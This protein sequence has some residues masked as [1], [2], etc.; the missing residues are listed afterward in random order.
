MIVLRKV[1]SPG[2]ISY[3]AFTGKSPEKMDLQITIGA[4]SE[5]LLDVGPTSIEEV[6]RIWEQLQKGHIITLRVVDMDREKN[7][8]YVDVS[9]STG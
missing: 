5:E 8:A 3:K 7:E 9:I 1:V 2:D 6:E 4:P